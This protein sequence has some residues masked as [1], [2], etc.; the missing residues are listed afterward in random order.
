MGR[1]HGVPLLVI[2]LTED[3]HKLM[4]VPNGEKHLSVDKKVTWHF[5]LLELIIQ[6]GE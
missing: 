5:G 3:S 1:A 6:F 2:L 4:S